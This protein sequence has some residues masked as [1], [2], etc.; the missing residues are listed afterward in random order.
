MA[1]T[2]ITNRSPAL[3]SERDQVSI[4]AP[5][6]TKFLRLRRLPRAV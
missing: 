4:W 2:Q 3:T 6:S 5:K 1:D